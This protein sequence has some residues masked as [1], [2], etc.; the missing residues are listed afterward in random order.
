MRRWEGLVGVDW[1]GAVRA[2][3]N[4]PGFDQTWSKLHGG[5]TIR[6]VAPKH[7]NEA[8]NYLVR[9][10]PLGIP[11]NITLRYSYVPTRYVLL[12][13]SWYEYEYVLF[14][15]STRVPNL[16]HRYYTDDTW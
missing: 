6:K 7:N 12:V 4:V 5:G 9:T 10:Y 1:S 11:T 16:Y 15:L 14:Y 3:G 2:H 8:W 13:G